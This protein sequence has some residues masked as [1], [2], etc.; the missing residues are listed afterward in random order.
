MPNRSQTLLWSK[1][2]TTSLSPMESPRIH[3]TFRLQHHGTSFAK[4]P[5]EMEASEKDKH[6]G[7]DVGRLGA[8]SRQGFT[9]VELLVVIVVIGVLSGIA[10]PNVSRMMDSYRVRAASRQLA[11]E[12]QYAKTKAIAENANYQVHFDVVNSRYRTEKSDGTNDGPWRNT[13]DATTAYNGNGVSLAKGFT[14]DFLIF[15]PI[16]EALDSAGAPLVADATVVLSTVGS[17]SKTVSIANS[18]RVQ[19]S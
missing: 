14:G 5:H 4:I 19:V 18:G 3:A 2:L 15:T 16:G 9:L 12:L 7:G 10:A 11:T 13:A 1:P 17:L 6:G 8:R